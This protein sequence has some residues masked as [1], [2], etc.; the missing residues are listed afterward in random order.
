MMARYG[1]GE[2]ETL[3]NWAEVEVKVVA[4]LTQL[5]SYKDKVFAKCPVVL[6]SLLL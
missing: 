3:V 2:T 6:S 4:H 5:I 1:R